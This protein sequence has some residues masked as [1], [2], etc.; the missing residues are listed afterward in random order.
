[1]AVTIKIFI[2]TERKS[3]FTLHLP[4]ITNRMLHV[5]VAAGHHSYAKRARLYVQIMKT[6]AKGSAEEIAIIIS[7]KKNGNHVVRYS[8]NEW[9]S[10]WNDLTTEQT[11]MKNSKS[12]CGISSSRFLNT[13]SVQRVWVQAIDQMSLTNQL[14]IK[15]A[16]EII[17]RDLANAQKL[18]D[19]KSMNGIGNW[20]EYMQHF[21]QK[22]CSIS[23]FFFN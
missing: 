19:K 20:F 14:S 23:Y 4:C 18:A 12:E 10:V 1:M 9:S 11:L 16:C 8:S 17:Q 7:L 15:K 13:E 2:C 5:F 22:I 21:N 3:D 6:Y